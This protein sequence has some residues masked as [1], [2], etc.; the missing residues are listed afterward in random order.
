VLYSPCPAVA[1]TEAIADDL[2]MDTRSMGYARPHVGKLELL[3]LD[4]WD[5]NETYDEDPP[6][7]LRY[8]IEWKV[9]LNNIRKAGR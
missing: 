8:S 9:T 1:H 2:S 4:E 7:C 6:T 5:E 3:N